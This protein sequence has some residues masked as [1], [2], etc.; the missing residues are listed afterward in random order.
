[1]NI[2]WAKETKTDFRRLHKFLVEAENPT[3]ADNIHNIIIE[4]AQNLAHNPKLGTALNDATNRRKWIIPFGKNAYI[5]H[6]I[7]ED[8]T[9]IILRIYHSREDR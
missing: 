7:I 9:I 5:L 4:G 6:Y 1:M 3:A 2:I 8:N